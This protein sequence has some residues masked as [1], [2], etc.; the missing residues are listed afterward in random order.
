MKSTIPNE[1]DIVN[2]TTNMSTQSVEE[3]RQG[4]FD[5]MRIF[6]TVISSVGIIANLT[7]VVVFI[8]HK[9]LRMKIPNIFIVNQVSNLNI[10]YLMLCILITILRHKVESV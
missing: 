6:T 7:V 5:T 8:N 1:T 4:T 2:V 9:K 3:G 10:S